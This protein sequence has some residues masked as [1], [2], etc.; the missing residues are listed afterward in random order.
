MQRPHAMDFEQRLQKAIQ[1]GQRRRDE[2]LREAEAKA[3]DDGEVRRL[4]SQY[5]LALSEH[6]E[7][8]MTRMPNHFPGFQFE[9]V[10]GERGW[11]AACSR[12]DLQVGP[13]GRRA[14]QYSRLE[15]T[16]RPLSEAHILEI[17]AKGT[18]RNKESFLR[19]HYDRLEDVDLDHFLALID[20]WV[21]DYAELY[22]AN[23]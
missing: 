19:S 13:R 16:V 5:R 18:I 7:E 15:I 2:Q 11:G 1:R 12:D 17:G 22:A 21:L 6:I 23:V 8:C 4:H 20:R 14:T 9:T 10:F 3:G